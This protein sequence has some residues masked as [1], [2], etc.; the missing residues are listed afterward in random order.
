MLNN[1][2][3][4]T[5]KVMPTTALRTATVCTQDTNICMTKHSYFP[6]TSTHSSTRHNTNIQHTSTLQGY[7][8]HY[9]K[10]R[11]LHKKHSHRPPHSHYN[12]HKTN[13]LHI[14]TYIISMHLATRGNN[15][16][17]RTPPPHISSSEEEKSP[18]HSS[19]PCPTPNKK[20]PLLKY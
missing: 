9:L 4:R 13:M 15:N 14:H 12:R 11:P 19:H 1:N 3:D 20:S 18:P 17:L 5:L 7:K 6:Y 16:I 10:Q 8:K 2:G